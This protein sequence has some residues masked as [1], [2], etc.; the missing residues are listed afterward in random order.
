[1]TIFSGRLCLFWIYISI[2]FIT[3][4]ISSKPSLAA[5]ITLIPSPSSGVAPL[6]VRLICQSGNITQ[7]ERY[8]IDFGDGSETE[9]VDSNSYSY[10]FTHTYESGYFTPTCFVET[11]TGL[12]TESDPASLIVA[13]WKFKTKGDVDCSPAIGLDGTVYFGSDDGNL[14]ALDPETGKERWIF[15]AGGE[16]QSSPAIGPDGT[17]YFGSLDNHFYAV[18]PTGM[19][20]WSMNIGDA[21]FSSPAIGPEGRVI[22]VGANDQNLYAIN[23][24]GTVK[25]KFKSNDK[26]ISAPSI[27]YD[28]IEDTI[29]FG[30]L[31]SHVYAL[32]ANNGKLKWSFK[33]NAAVY[34]SP[35]IGSNG[36]IYI[37][38]CL[39]GRAE[40]YNFKFY[41]LNVDGTKLWEFNGGTGFYSSPAI[42]NKGN[43]YVGSWDGTLY[44][45]TSGGY[46]N[47]EAKTDPLSDINTSPALGANGIVYVGSK[48]GN[49]YA[50]NNSEI[51]WLFKTDGEIQYSS[52]AIDDNGTIY[53][54]S[55]DDCLYAINPGDMEPAESQWP[56]FHQSPNHSG[57]APD[58]S[59]L[60]IVSTYPIYGTGNIDIKT[61]Q[62]KFTFAPDIDASQVDIESFHL[63]REIDGEQ[64]EVVGGFSYIDFVQYNNSA[65]TVAAIFSREK[66]K[67]PLEYLSLYTASIS[68]FPSIAEDKKATAL[69][70][71][72]TEPDPEGNNSSDSNPKADFGCFITTIY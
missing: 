67:E 9:T 72:V 1:M 70:S 22:Y 27:G 6:E 39:I 63:I 12:E 68:F 50:Y 44:S 19:L 38:E 71:F 51:Q 7:P 45:L 54:G 56:M 23:S 41:R 35:A 40:E 46:L 10:I 49:F 64:F 11:E 57:I 36:E 13:K 30:S 24:S 62:F 26:I 18:M 25:W 43:L 33:T 48:N 21:I 52:P 58:I 37:G 15:S 34:G 59:I 61:E 42:G 17:I 32:A 53:F 16:I 20:K 66:E 8:V 2:F 60:P 28:G 3:I 5:S 55:R 29:Y 47:W 65:Y 4:G 31:D 14:Y 69:T